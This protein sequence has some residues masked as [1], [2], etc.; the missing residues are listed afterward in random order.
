MSFLSFTG[1]D[2]GRY[3]D[4]IILPNKFPGPLSSGTLTLFELVGF[5]LMS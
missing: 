5:R 2:L 3:Q 4:Y 1:D